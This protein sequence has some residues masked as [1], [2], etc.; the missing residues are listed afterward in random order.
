[1]T[2]ATT[3]AE[4]P[5]ASSRSYRVRPA[6]SLGP[7]ASASMRARSVV[8]IEVTGTSEWGGSGKLK[9]KVREGKLLDG[10]KSQQ[11]SSWR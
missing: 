2:R 5:L 4:K 9:Q 10:N 11:T 6:L 8:G 1:M 3:S 7:R